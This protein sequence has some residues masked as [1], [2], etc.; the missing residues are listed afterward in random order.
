MMSLV[1]VSV[2][3]PTVENSEL[4]SKSTR[5]SVACNL[6]RETK[7]KCLNNNDNTRC[8]RCT[9]LDLDCSYTLKKSQ[10]KKR[11]LS[12]HYLPSNDN[13]IPK[14]QVK[15]PGLNLKAPILTVS[16]SKDSINSLNENN[17][18]DNV[19]D[20][21]NLR[22]KPYYSIILPDRSTI[23]EVAEIYFENQ[24]KGI[25][26][27]L[28]KPS[29]ISF[30]R[31][32]EFNPKSYIIDYYNDKFDTCY[33]SSLKY[34]DPVILLAILALCARLHPDMPKM[35]GEFSEDKSPQLYI[36]NLS[37]IRNQTPIDN[38]NNHAASNASNYFGWHARNILKEVF[39][40][41][42]IQRVQA[43]TILSSHEWGEGCSSRSYLYVGIAAR[44]VFLLG[45]GT[46]NGLFSKEDEE[47][48]LDEAAKFICIESK[49]RTMWAVYMMD[50]CNSSGRNRHSCVRLDDIQVKLPSTEK[51]FIF[52]NYRQNSLTFEEANRYIHDPTKRHLLNDTSCFGFLIIL[53]ETW[54]KIAKWCGETGGKLEKLLPWEKDSPY[55]IL[56]KELDT[57]RDSLPVHLQFNHFNLEAHIA[58]GS[59]A[60][61]S[62]FHG[63]F[64]LCRIFLNREYFFCT[65]FSFP[66]GWWEN[67]TRV[68]LETLD[69]LTYITRTLKPINMMVIAPFTGFQVFTVAATSLYFNAFPK[70]FLLQNFPLQKPTANDR[71][72]IEVDNLK[73]KYKDLADETLGNLKTWRKVWGLGNGWYTTSLKLQKM[74]ATVAKEN[75]SAVQDDDLRHSMH[76]YGNGKVGEVFK[77]EYTRD[78]KD[79]NISSLLIPEHD[80]NSPKPYLKHT[81]TPFTHTLAED[82]GVSSEVSSP[83]LDFINNFDLSNIFPGWG[84]ATKI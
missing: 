7:L 11:K 36:P 15:A 10:L 23:L 51:D 38:D 75:S 61:F 53:F 5:A 72:I 24:Y 13:S 59:A 57:F 58:D 1:S 31:S 34:P 20:I 47:K 2:S 18:I 45:L 54:A 66:D 43:L 56:S 42:T 16:E 70:K 26:P 27:H 40:S 81:P 4:G 28:H 76:D 12:K 25:F 60:D 73:T 29:I 68:L 78:K 80:K 64:F 21:S 74:F 48:N 62:Y 9:L 32:P 84:D 50:R 65:P 82:V 35:Y 44:M 30:I 49:R 14:S 46:E 71:L 52:G 22:N 17:R 6:C 63:L 39:D 77:P 33:T 69:E 67:E 83:S 79:M 37:N 3:G 8:Q 55:Y 19:D 41:P